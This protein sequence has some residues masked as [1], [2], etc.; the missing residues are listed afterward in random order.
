MRIKAGYTSN[1][2]KL[3]APTHIP[4]TSVVTKLL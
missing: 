3:K 1:I 4:T 2:T